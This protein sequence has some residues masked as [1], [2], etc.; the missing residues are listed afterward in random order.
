M[1]PVLNTTF[2]GAVDEPGLFNEKCLGCGD[3]VL[4][5]TGGICPIA[6]CAKKLFNGPCGGSSKGRCEVSITMGRDI[7]CAWHLIVDRLK[8][9]DQLDN[10]EKIAAMKTWSPSAAGGPRQL[11]HPGNLPG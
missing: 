6:R 11:L 3:C 1:L 7:D 8:D 4:G 2:I 10:Y 9:L 5:L